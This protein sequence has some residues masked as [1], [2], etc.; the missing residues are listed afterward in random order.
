MRTSAPLHTHCSHTPSH[1]PRPR[2]TTQSRR[3]TTDA[4]VQRRTS[5]EVPEDTSRP[6]WQ[7]RTTLVAVHC[8][9]R[10][11]YPPRSTRRAGGCGSALCPPVPPRR[12]ASTRCRRCSLP[13]EPRTVA[14]LRRFPGDTAPASASIGDQPHL[15]LD[16]FVSDSSRPSDRGATTRCSAFT[17][18]SPQDCGLA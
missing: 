5:Q 9:P 2:A 4:R 13:I 7:S 17:V 8:L 15:L 3:T 14:V 10:L 1:S 16:S 18:E 6:A 12:Y 11:R